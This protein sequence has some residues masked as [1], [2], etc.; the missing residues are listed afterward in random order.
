[1]ELYLFSFFKILIFLCGFMVIISKNPIHSI[2]FLI[3]VF[4]NVSALLIMLDVEFLGIIFLV[5]YVG[6]IAVLFLFVV[7]MLNIRISE[8]SEE[9]LSYFPISAIIALIFFIEIYCLFLNNL[10]LFPFQLSLSWLY[11]MNA[12]NNIEVLGEVMYTYYFHLFLI[13]S[14]ILLVAMIG[15][16]VLTLHH[17]LD[18]K[19]QNIFDQVSTDFTLKINMK[20]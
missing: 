19:R 4:F 11:S 13:A 20:K 16:I 6:A 9:F 2:L 17:K 1:M 15:S 18:V 8:I 10:S 7:M 3:L 5:V 12:I 14:I